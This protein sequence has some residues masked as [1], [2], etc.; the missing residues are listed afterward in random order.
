ML[1]ENAKERIRRVLRTEYDLTYYDRLEQKKVEDT[2][3]LNA[4]QIRWDRS[5]APKTYP[6]IILNFTPEGE[7]R[8]EIGHIFEDGVFKEEAPWDDSIAYVQYNAKPMVGT[9]QVTV[10]ANREHTTPEG[11]VIPKRVVADSL[12]MQA[13]HDYQYESDHL[14]EQGVD[15]EGE[16]LEYAWP[17]RVRGIVDGAADTSTTIDDNAVQRRSMPFRVEYAY[18]AERE[19]PAVAAI[20]YALYLDHNRDGEFEHMYDDRIDLDELWEDHNEDD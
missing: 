15:V 9:L 2:I 20:E 12:M 3:E 17:M 8:G 10:A 4:S 14:G 6:A 13:F 7:P 19:V 1:H 18:F 11:D 16:D 5:D